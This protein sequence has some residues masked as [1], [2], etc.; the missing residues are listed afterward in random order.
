MSNDYGNKLQ[1]RKGNMKETWNFLNDYGWQGKQIKADI[2]LEGLNRGDS[3]EIA[4]TS[5]MKH[6]IWNFS[7]ARVKKCVKLSVTEV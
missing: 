3:S 5:V 7:R 6:K 1:Q 2:N 4:N